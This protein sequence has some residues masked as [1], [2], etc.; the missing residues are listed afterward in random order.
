[1][2]KEITELIKKKI[3]KGSK[4][5]DYKLLNYNNKLTIF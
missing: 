4:H 5:Y 1:M 3:L 2:I